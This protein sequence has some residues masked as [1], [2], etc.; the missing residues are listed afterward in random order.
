MGS[1]LRTSYPVP[2]LLTPAESSDDELADTTLEYEADRLPAL[3][4]SITSSGSSAASIKVVIG[5]DGDGD[6]DMVDSQ[7]QEHFSSPQ[8]W[9]R[10][11]SND[12]L[13]P[14]QSPYLLETQ[15][16]LGGERIAT[17]IYGYFSGNDVNLD[18]SG[19]PNRPSTS[20]SPLIREE[21]ESHWW[22]GHRLPSPVE[23]SEI[24]TSSMGQANGMMGRLNVSTADSN[25]S[26]RMFTPISES[27]MSWQEQSEVQ[28]G[29]LAGE[30]DHPRS[31]RLT[32]GY[33]ADCHKCVQRVPGHYSHIVWD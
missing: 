30:A 16:R 3:D 8:P 12:M 23:Q 5:D 24:H 21:E 18:R 32:M 25:L 20:L 13:A 31:G 28:I 9:Q 33:R 19:T 17:P 4:D 27:P 6:M 7:P 1:F 11:R 14:P 26:S 15:Q 22:R 10:Q 29:R 2:T